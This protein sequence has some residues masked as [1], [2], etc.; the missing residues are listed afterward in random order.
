VVL[1]GSSTEPS[2]DSPVLVEL[3]GSG[4]E[5]PGSTDVELEETKVEAASTSEE[6]D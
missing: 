3:P 6:E 4:V 5:L 2:A 1:C